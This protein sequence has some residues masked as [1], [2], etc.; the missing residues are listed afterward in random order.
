MLAS[1]D[2]TNS[3]SSAPTLPPGDPIFK[4]KPLLIEAA[5]PVT[6][7]GE[8]VTFCTATNG[9]ARRLI[10]ALTVSRI[11]FFPPP[12]PPQHLIS[13][14]CTS[15]NKSDRSFTCSSLSN[16][17]RKVELPPGRH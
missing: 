3:L 5:V 16:T 10:T 4:R 14:R 8:F 6:A 1:I 9:N 12:G 13:L 17:W 11:P 15:D 7:D 2:L